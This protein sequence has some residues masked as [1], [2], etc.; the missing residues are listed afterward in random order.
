MPRNRTDKDRKKFGE[1]GFGKFIKKI[2]GAIPALAGDILDIATSGNPIGATIDKVKGIIMDKMD[3]GTPE[4]KEAASELMIELEKN[5]QDY[6]L[7]IFELEVEDRASARSREVEMAKSG[8]KS[9]TQNIL[10][11]IG[12]LGFFGCLAVLFFGPEM[13]GNQETILNILIGTL[14]T[15]NISIFAYYFGSSKGSKDKTEMLANG[16]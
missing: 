6:E 4:E 15:I 16:N 13:K 10:A 5:R 14:A 7:E 3:M 2:G 12:V 8:R 9:Y 11:F 1:T